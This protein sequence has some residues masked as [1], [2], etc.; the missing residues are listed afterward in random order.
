MFLIKIFATVFPFLFLIQNAQA[1][2]CSE[3]I[4]KGGL[5]AHPILEPLPSQYKLV[6]TS[7]RGSLYFSELAERKAKAIDAMIA[8]RE[9]AAEIFGVGLTRTY[10]ERLI[11]ED[12]VVPAEDKILFIG[13][14]FMLKEVLALVTALEH[15]KQLR[16][17]VNEHGLYIKSDNSK[18]DIP[19]KP[20]IWLHGDAALQALQL[21]N[22]RRLHRGYCTN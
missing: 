9:I 6:A 22:T 8:E 18:Y 13:G 2:S 3:A 4:Q 7:S 11:V 14:I 1:S 17:E 21:L 16:L 10:N 15:S 5:T 12:V 19:V 20:E